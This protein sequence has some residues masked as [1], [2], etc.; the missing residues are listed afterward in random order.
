MAQDLKSI[1][2]EAFKMQLFKLSN[3]QLVNLLESIYKLKTEYGH[4]M[5]NDEIID[6]ERKE[7]KLNAELMRRGF[8]KKS[9]YDDYFKWL[10]TINKKKKV[11]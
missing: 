5:N 4:I 1:S 7:T 3:K 8:L 11:W 9:D 10:K 6:L 2:Q